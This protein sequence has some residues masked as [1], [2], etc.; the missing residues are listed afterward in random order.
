MIRSTHTSEH[1][2]HAVAY[3]FGL[4]AARVPI[5]AL[6]V[7]EMTMAATFAAFGAHVL[8]GGAYELRTVIAMTLRT[9][10]WVAIAWAAYRG[11]LRSP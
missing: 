5:T 2:A 3:V 11:V 6:L 4:H 10:V 1:A 9:L 7:K 8:S